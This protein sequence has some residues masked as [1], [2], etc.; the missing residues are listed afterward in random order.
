MNGIKRPKKQGYFHTKCL[1]VELNIFDVKYV[2]GLAF[3]VVFFDGKNHVK[4][5]L[6]QIF[7]VAAKLKTSAFYV[8]I[9]R[10]QIEF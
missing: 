4:I 10:G 5:F 1:G 2:A 3:P 8:S 7:M 6:L 9:F